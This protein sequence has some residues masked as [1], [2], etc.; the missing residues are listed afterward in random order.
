MVLRAGAVVG[1]V[2]LSKVAKQQAATLGL[3]ALAVVVLGLAA[4]TALG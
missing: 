4:S 2:V 3:P 1:Q